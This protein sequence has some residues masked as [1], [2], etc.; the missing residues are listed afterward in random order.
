MPL[1]PY[2][3]FIAH[4]VLAP[5]LPATHAGAILSL[6]RQVDFQ[7]SQL[8]KVN[9]ENEL[10]QKE[11]RER[12]Q[13]LQAMTDKVAVASRAPPQLRGA[14]FS[15][16]TDGEA[17]RRAVGTLPGHTTAPPAALWPERPSCHLGLLALGHFSGISW[18]P[19][20]RGQSPTRT[21][22]ADHS[23]EPTPC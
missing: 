2:P 22:G 19:S 21:S 3:T 15:H 8:Q 4:P 20:P 17:E 13:Q 5:P 9:T 6:Q 18:P 23:A 1:A 11:L 14:Q 16:P 12:K 10:L 7:E